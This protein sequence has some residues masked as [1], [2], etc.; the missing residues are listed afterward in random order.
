MVWLF[1]DDH[2][3]LCGRARPCMASG[4]SRLP[5]LRIA[6]AMEEAGVGGKGVSVKESTVPITAR[7]R[8]RAEL[9]AAMD[10][11]KCDHGARLPFF[12]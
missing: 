4:A 9:R 11:D 5:W 2:S 8:C 6:S 10:R 1:G 3:V 12:P 7:R